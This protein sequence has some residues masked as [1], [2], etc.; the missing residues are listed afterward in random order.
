MKTNEEAVHVEDPRGYRAMPGITTAF[1][2]Y[3]LAAII[4]MNC[5]MT[6]RTKRLHLRNQSGGDARPLCLSI[7][8]REHKLET[9][10]VCLWSLILGYK[11][12]RTA[13]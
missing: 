12:E 7:H 13:L 9:S 2:R 11:I 3:H 5:C 8:H 1:V 10:R 4:V 6:E